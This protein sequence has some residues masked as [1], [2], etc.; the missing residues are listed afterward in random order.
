ML[1]YEKLYGMLF[2]G[3]TD[4][5]GD[6]RDKDF[7]MAEDTLIRIQQQAEDYYI[8]AYEEDPTEPDRSTTVLPIISIDAPR[9]N[10]QDILRPNS[11]KSD[12]RFI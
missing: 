12:G 4:A 3:I 6:M 1:S 9:R 8:R 5:L 11:G 2:N 7:N 10:K